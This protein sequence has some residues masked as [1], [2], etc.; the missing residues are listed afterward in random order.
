VF[1]GDFSF[2]LANSSRKVRRVSRFS[3]S[4][5]LEQVPQLFAHIFRRGDRLGDLGQY[6]LPK[7]AAEA[8]DGDLKD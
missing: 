3:P 4:V 1:A 8:R 2:S 5:R 7:T 6:E